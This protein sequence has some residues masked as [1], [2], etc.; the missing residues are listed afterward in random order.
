MK[1]TLYYRGSLT[2]CN[3][4]CP[5]CPF[6]KNKDSAATLAKDKAYI[7]KFVDWVRR[8]GE[9]GHR[10]SVFFNPYGEGLV[11]RWYRAAMIELSRMEHVDK[12]AIQTNLSVKLDW[13]ADLNPQK[14][15]F[16][17]TYHPGQTEE[18]AFLRQCGELYRRGIRFSVGSVGLK[19]AFQALRSLRK[20]LPP[21]AYMWV[22]AYKDRPDYYA[23]DDLE[24]LQS[25][26]PHFMLNAADYESLGRPCKAGCD[27]F[28][29]QGDGRVKRCYKDRQIIGNLYRDGLEGLSRQ[30]A[31]RM[32][33]CDCYIGYIHMPELKLDSVYG[34]GLLE[35]IAP[36]AER[37]GGDEGAAE[38]ASLCD[39]VDRTA[40]FR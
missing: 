40:Q 34:N 19:S 27:V 7:G 39:M 30:R 23:Q 6:S 37:E 36:M 14:A 17:A 2:S 26:D 22:N 35:R 28:Y 11:H 12:V 16:W 33:C 10:L 18:A 4:D 13:T 8:Q 38:A 20:A 5:Y 31:C 32:A 3:Y 15:A 9:E 24:L 29:V 25:I 21:D 1:A